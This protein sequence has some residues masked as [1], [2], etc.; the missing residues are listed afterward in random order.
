MFRKVRPD[1]ANED[2]IDK[3]PQEYMEL[4]EDL[5]EYAYLNVGVDQ[6]AELNKEFMLIDA[7]LWYFFESKYTGYKIMRPVKRAKGKARFDVDLLEIRFVILSDP[8]ILQIKETDDEYY[9]A[10]YNDMV[11]I[12]KQQVPSFWTMTDLRAFIIKYLKAQYKF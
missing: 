3:Q 9:K 12:L 5:Q 6:S 8:E 1:K 11:K 7:D 10:N 2:I 4:P